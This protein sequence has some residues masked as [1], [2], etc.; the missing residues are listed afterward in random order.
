MASNFEAFESDV[1]HGTFIATAN[2]LHGMFPP[3]LLPPL[4]SSLLPPSHTQKKRRDFLL[5]EYFRRGNY[6]YYSFKLIQKNQR[7]VKLQSLQFYLNSK[8]IELQRVKTVIILGKMVISIIC[9][10]SSFSMSIRCHA[11]SS[12]SLGFAAMVIVFS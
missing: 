9:F 12:R 4:L 3:L 5:Q 8:T 7:R 1:A 11:L 10:S 6:F 2:E